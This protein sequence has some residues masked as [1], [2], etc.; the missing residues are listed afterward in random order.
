MSFDYKFKG[1]SV[2]WI[3][4]V[5]S[6]RWHPS[7][8]KHIHKNVLTPNSETGK[9]SRLFLF[10]NKSLFGCFNEETFRGRFLHCMSLF[11][12]VWFSSVMLEEKTFNG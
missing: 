8:I 4:S 10:I 5:K 7:G 6:D 9:S 11:A 2:A 3:S 12:F 1:R